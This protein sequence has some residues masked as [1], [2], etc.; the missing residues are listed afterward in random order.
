MYLFIYYANSL[1]NK[2]AI[3]RAKV[4]N[5]KYSVTYNVTSNECIA[6][7][8]QILERSDISEYMKE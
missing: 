2:D 6:G 4:S 8:E 1:T 5:M 7:N 3:N